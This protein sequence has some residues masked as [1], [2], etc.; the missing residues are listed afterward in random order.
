MTFLA[1]LL[2]ARGAEKRAIHANSGTLGQ[3]F[4]DLNAP[5]SKVRGANDWYI[6]DS[7]GQRVVFDKLTDE[8]VPLTKSFLKI[9]P[10]TYSFVPRPENVQMELDY[11]VR[12]GGFINHSFSP[13]R[14][15]QKTFM[16]RS[17]LKP[18]SNTS[19]DIR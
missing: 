10:D 2:N 12:G 3:L 9:T 7:N 4:D 5:I 15:F 14:P 8:W 16:L 11:F 13:L 18:I 19:A 17:A 6:E 1:D